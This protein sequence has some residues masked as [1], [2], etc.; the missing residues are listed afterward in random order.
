MLVHGSELGQFGE[1]IDQLFTT[2]LAILQAAIVGTERS[3]RARFHILIPQ[4]CLTRCS[5]S[6][7][8]TL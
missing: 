6:Q 3:Y 4:S 5:I 7:M 2:P 8:A 1:N